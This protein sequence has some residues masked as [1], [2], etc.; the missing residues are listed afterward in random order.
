MKSIPFLQKVSGFVISTLPFDNKLKAD[1]VE[2]INEVLDSIVVEKMAEF[3]LIVDALELI[4][5]EANF[6]I[7]YSFV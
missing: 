1:Y 5:K 4:V 6:L 3:D 7:T 2:S